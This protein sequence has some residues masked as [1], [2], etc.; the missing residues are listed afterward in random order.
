M[1]TGN[2]GVGYLVLPEVGVCAAVRGPGQQRGHGAGGQQQRVRVGELSAAQRAQV[3][4]PEHRGF[5]YHG[6]GPY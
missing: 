1:A 5:Q 4:S 6:E 3:T 2:A